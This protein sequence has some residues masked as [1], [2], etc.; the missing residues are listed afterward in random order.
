MPAQQSDIVPI[1]MPKWG[2]SMDEGLLVAWLKAPGERFSEGDELAEIE[3]SKINNVFEAPTSGLLRRVVAVAGDTIPVGGLLAVVAETE[4]GDDA[5]ERFISDFQA[6]F[7]PEDAEGSAGSTIQKRTVEVAGQSINIAIAGEGEPAAVLLHGFGGDVGS[8]ALNLNEFAETRRVIAIDLPGHGASTK[9][10]GSGSVADLAQAVM[11]SLDALGIERPHLIG[12]SLGG[13][14]A[15]HLA[16]KNTSK[17]RS[18]VLVA[19]AGLPGSHLN[20]E[21]LDGLVEAQRPRDFRPL[22]QLLFHDQRLASEE[23]SANLA[24]YKRIDGVEEALAAIR[25]Q[26]VT[27]PEDIAPD[28]PPGYLPPILIVLGEADQVAGPPDRKALPADWR[29]VTL[30]QAGHMPMAEQSAAF[31]RLV[32]DF[33]AEIP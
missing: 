8:W 33:L 25:D 22:V 6:S 11:G 27:D 9:N 20:R 16:N 24:R 15:F 26:L 31:N 12:H 18:V 13:T 29:V 7:V 1:R 3:T 14:I 10:V 23:M 19:P 4:V 30:P 5:I 21:F 32:I 28:G 2:L 17:F